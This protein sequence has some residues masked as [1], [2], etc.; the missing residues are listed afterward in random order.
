[1]LSRHQYYGLKG[2]AG[3][4]FHG[5]AGRPG[6]VGG[7]SEA[8]ALSYPNTVNGQIARLKSIGVKIVSVESFLRDDFDREIP[9][10]RETKYIREGL[11]SLADT[12]SEAQNS[13]L[14]IPKQ[15]GVG[16]S[17]P[18]YVS[19]SLHDASAYYDPNDES[20]NV[21]HLSYG[22]TSA[23]EQAQRAKAVYATGQLSSDHPLNVFHHEYAHFL[24]DLNS[25]K[26]SGYNH[27]VTYLN[28]SQRAIA[29]RV[30]NYATTN[31]N[32]FVAETAAGIMSGKTYDA[33]VMKLYRSFDGPTVT[34]RKRRRWQRQSWARGPSGVC[35]RQHG[36]NNRTTGRA[37][38]FRQFYTSIATRE[39]CAPSDFGRLR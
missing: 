13:N 1:M 32:E 25:S 7:S 33:E 19:E 3:S 21:N 31:S 30:S 4:G 16:S 8:S 9:I 39:C 36:C 22:I 11:R 35:G 15:V 28:E 10:Y 27:N 26:D 24:H 2:G 23:E 18:F 34:V 38:S 29:K 37:H 6:Q 5:H 14:P 20:L 12:F 17:L